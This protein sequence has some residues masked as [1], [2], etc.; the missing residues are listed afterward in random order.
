[1]AKRAE[2]AI[3]DSEGGVATMPAAPEGSAERLRNSGDSIAAEAKE[4]AHDDD[5][6]LHPPKESIEPLGHAFCRTRAVHTSYCALVHDR[7]HDCDCHP[8]PP[9][10]IEICKDCGW[11]FSDHNPDFGKE[12][13]VPG[14]T[15]IHVTDYAANGESV[16]RTVEPKPSK[17]AALPG[18]DGHIWGEYDGLALSHRQFSFGGSPHFPRELANL[19][20]N[21]HLRA[22]DRQHF[23]V[24]GIVG[25]SEFGPDAHGIN[26]GKTKFK[27]D[28]VSLPGKGEAAPDER[29]DDIPPELIRKSMV[30]E[31]VT[32]AAGLAATG[33]EP[34][35][36]WEIVRDLSHLFDPLPFEEDDEPTLQTDADP[37]A[38]IENASNGEN[39]SNSPEKPDSS[40]LDKSI[41]VAMAEA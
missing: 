12:P 31:L 19:F 13:P 41:A 28:A 35:E 15:Q 38:E 4:S 8:A 7:D 30:T 18:T 24:T 10:P 2:Q 32:R 20:P 16:D 23:V 11:P 36:A 25:K 6:V 29:K 37:Q 39:A 5:F 33:G 14:D 27:I 22:G 21:G 34:I 40:Q 17:Q 9:L 1:M 26:F 3:I